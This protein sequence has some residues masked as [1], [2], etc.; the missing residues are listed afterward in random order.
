MFAARP[1]RHPVIMD[2]KIL[3]AWLVILPVAQRVRTPAARPARPLA[4]IGVKMP[5]AQLARQAAV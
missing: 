4:A 3:A 5:A 1:A 2:V